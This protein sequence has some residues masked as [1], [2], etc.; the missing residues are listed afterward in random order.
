MGFPVPLNSLLGAFSKQDLM[1]R[2]VDGQLVSSGVFSRQ[3]IKNA[4]HAAVDK[5]IDPMMVWMLLSLELYM[6]NIG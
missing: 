2:L 4:V 5:N 6:E 1:E 3:G